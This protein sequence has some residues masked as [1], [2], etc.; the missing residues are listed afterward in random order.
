MEQQQEAENIAIMKVQS[1]VRG[2][3]SR[4]SF[5]RIKC[6]NQRI[7]AESI[8]VHM[9]Q[10]AARNWQCQ[11]KR[12]QEKEKFDQQSIASDSLCSAAV[13]KLAVDSLLTAF[14]VRTQRFALECDVQVVLTGIAVGFAERKS[15]SKRKSSR[16]R[17][18]TVRKSLQC[19]LVD[20]IQRQS[21]C[22]KANKASS[23]M[24][25]QAV[26]AAM[27]ADANST[28]AI[29]LNE[30]QGRMQ[31][32]LDELSEQQEEAAVDVLVQFI[33]DFVRIAQLG[34]NANA[35]QATVLNTAPGLSCMVRDCRFRRE[36]AVL[37]ACSCR[38]L[39]FTSRLE[40][41]RHQGDTGIALTTESMT[42]EFMMSIEQ[43]I[44]KNVLKALAKEAVADK[45]SSQQLEEA[46]A[47]MA[48]RLIKSINGSVEDAFRDV[49]ASV[50]KE[51]TAENQTNTTASEISVNSKFLMADT[52]KEEQDRGHKQLLV[53]SDA[54]ENVSDD[55]EESSGSGSTSSATSDSGSSTSSDFSSWDS[56]TTTS[57]GS[58]EDDGSTSDDDSQ[59]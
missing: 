6:N 11:R 24:L 38:R 25:E 34:V 58:S 4:I 54:E 5:S 19:H 40:L 49:I 42:N 21:N 29:K 2:R 53:D 32:S 57:D 37:S 15:S 55:A 8:A 14:A 56:D 48:T 16:D 36:Q 59:M 52:T 39:F 28:S 12:Q 1:L 10:S 43:K 51:S 23:L 17:L 41:A 47:F 30:V 22:N 7:E 27:D 3:F 20:F 44:S 13:V 31:A 9:I 46:L 18:S 26:V 33:E 35:N 45:S 50:D